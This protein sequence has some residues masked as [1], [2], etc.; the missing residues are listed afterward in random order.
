MLEHPEWFL[1]QPDPEKPENVRTMGE[2]ILHLPYSVNLRCTALMMLTM[3]WEKRITSRELLHI[4]RKNIEVCNDAERILNE[5]AGNGNSAAGLDDED[6]GMRVFGRRYG[7][8]A[9]DE[10]PTGG[11]PPG[12]GPPVGQVNLTQQEAAVDAE[13]GLLQQRLLELQR[14]SQEARQ[15]NGGQVAGGLVAGGGQGITDSGISEIA[16]VQQSEPPEPPEPQS[17]SRRTDSYQP[18]SIDSDPDSS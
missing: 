4:C 5:Q 13:L 2:E 1:L 8:M 3:N 12:Q 10:P 15:D 16:S 14:D 7:M 11:P 6:V 17:Q 9:P 18:P